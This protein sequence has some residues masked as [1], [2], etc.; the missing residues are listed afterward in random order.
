METDGDCRYFA[1]NDSRASLAG[2][3][4]EV[5][6]TF[7]SSLRYII[8]LYLT[9]IF[10][11][12]AAIFGGASTLLELNRIPSFLAQRIEPQCRCLA[13]IAAIRSVYSS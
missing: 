6:R 9:F 1:A 5:A 11:A 13:I 3:Q 10:T 2:R 8:M 7:I 12:I 4:R